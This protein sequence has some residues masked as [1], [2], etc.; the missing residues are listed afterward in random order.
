[1]IFKFRRWINRWEWTV[2]LLKL[3]RAEKLHNAPGLVMIQIDGLS[4]SQLEAALARNEMPF[5]KKLL[6]K[7]KYRFHPLYTGLPSTTPAI[8][9]EL[10]YGVKQIVPAFFFFD[11]E[12]RK[13]FR[14]FDGDSVQ[15][16]ERR[17]AE[18]GEG[19]LDGGSSYSNLY[20]GGA[21]EAHFCAGSLGWNHIWKDINPFNFLLLLVTHFPAVARMVFLTAWETFLALMDF[22]YGLLK[23]ENVVTEVKFV[24]LRVL[25]CILLRELV[26]LG[27]I[28]DA[29]RGLPVIHLNFIGYDEQAHRR[30]PGSRT[31]HWALK[32][33]DKAI[34][35][36]YSAAIHSSRRHYDVW[37]YSDHG[38]EETIPYIGHYGRG[39]EETITEIFENLFLNKEKPLSPVELKKAHDRGIQLER[40]RYLGH[41]VEEHWPAQSDAAP[42]PGHEIVVTAMGAV[43]GVYIFKELSLQQKLL[44]ARELTKAAKIPLVLL[45]QED[46]RVLAFTEK[47][48]FRLPEQ[49][50]EIIGREHPY[51]EEVA[52][53]LLALSHHPNA[54]T[55]TISGWRL[56]AKAY[57][58]PFENG[59]HAGPGT[60]ETNAFALLPPDAVPG[61]PPYLRTRDL[62]E[63]ALDLLRGPRAN[64]IFLRDPPKELEETVRSVRIM[65]YNVHS[66]VGMDG[67]ISPERI[68][69]VITRYEPD[70]VALQELDMG[71][72][73]TGAIDQ[74]HLI[75]KKLEM[76]YHFHPVIRVE[77]E[78]YGNA[79]LSRFPVEL[80]RAAPLPGLGHRKAEPRGALWVS[81]KIGN[82]RL[83]V[84]NTHLSFYAAE[85]RHQ[86][87]A[88]L[89]SD[90][91]GHPDCRDPVILCGDFNALP[92]STAWKTISRRLGDA[93][94]LLEKHRPLATWF[95][96]YPIGRIDHIF[97]SPGIK[98]LAIDVPRTYL[99]RVASD[100]L[101]LI[102]DLKLERVFS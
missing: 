91:L 28:I 21:Q 10:F 34:S 41:W 66:C 35:K 52:K 27:A 63:S 70:I 90:W 76:L 92:N 98:V 82:T 61:K 54:G 68:A 42:V 22:I 85:C 74:P 67:K 6:A 88:L 11:K 18:K 81:I 100:H 89:N 31:A 65:T 72:K 25:M 56:N 48:E 101:P 50:A 30:G 64:K 75:A 93:Q 13:V 95:S 19:L 86:A 23:R 77:E 3:S 79:V 32:G 83:Q 20:T 94:K 43:G 14:M 49:A 36:I 84:L 7:E 97:I 73:R 99:N 45:P 71:R 24:A 60:E 26:T 69:R 8:Q 102:A 58:F 40:A 4:K 53:D 39:V 33:I 55:L 5:L 78:N 16:I 62:R 15:E 96:H 29:A 47:G 37:V 44:F 80:V 38:Q 87:A 12:T 2:R 17:L 59:A 51:F 1:M 46:G 9:G 57:S